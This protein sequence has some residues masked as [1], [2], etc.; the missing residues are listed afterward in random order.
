MPVANSNQCL[1]LVQPKGV[2]DGREHVLYVLLSFVTLH[3]INHFFD[4]AVVG[5]VSGQGL[6]TTHT[7]YPV[8]TH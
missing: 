5:V 6:Q 3:H 2:H 8:V 1:T 7:S 4:D